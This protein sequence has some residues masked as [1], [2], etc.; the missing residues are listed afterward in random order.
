MVLLANIGI[1]YLLFQGKSSKISHFSK[2]KINRHMHESKNSMNNFV[3]I[4]CQKEKITN[5]H[6][7]VLLWMVME[8]NCV[9]KI[10]GMKVAFKWKHMVLK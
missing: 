8:K 3:K 6:V 9:T 10:F 7:A 2:L 1:F 4:F 5:L